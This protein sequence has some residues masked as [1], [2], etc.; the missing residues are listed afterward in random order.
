MFV[1]LI[2]TFIFVTLV[3]DGNYIVLAINAHLN[4]QVHLVCRT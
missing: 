1:E 3:V 2:V 4:Q